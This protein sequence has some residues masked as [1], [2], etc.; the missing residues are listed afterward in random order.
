MKKYVQ[1]LHINFFKHVE[2]HCYVILQLKTS[3]LESMFSTVQ[4]R[5]FKRR[6]CFEGTCRLH[7]QD[8]R[9]N[10][11]NIRDL[12]GQHCV[13]TKKTIL[14]TATAM[15]TSNLPHYLLQLLLKQLRWSGSHP[16]TFRRSQVG[17]QPWSWPSWQG[18]VVPFIPENARTVPSITP[19]LL[20]FSYF[21]IHCS[22]IFP[23][24]DTTYFKL[25]KASLIKSYTDVDIQM[26]SHNFTKMCF[27]F[28]SIYRKPT[29]EMGRWRTSGI[30]CDKPHSI[31]QYCHFYWFTNMIRNREKRGSTHW[32]VCESS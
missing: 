26:H 22:L 2:L 4:S 25:L 9:V 20:P 13:T 21:Q 19:R 6:R 28:I 10:L 24:F 29:L 11:Q 1:C 7:L 14:F 23:S 5:S 32:A 17:S 27:N 30:W 15:R 12:S 8:Q 18:F 31:L 3:L 16:F